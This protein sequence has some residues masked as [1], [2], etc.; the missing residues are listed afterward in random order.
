MLTGFGE[1]ALVRRGL[2]FL[3]C[4]CRGVLSWKPFL[5]PVCQTAP[6]SQRTAAPFPDAARGVVWV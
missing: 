5:R 1:V 2:R 3:R 4:A 6:S